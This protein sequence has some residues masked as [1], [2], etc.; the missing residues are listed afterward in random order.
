MTRRVKT[1]LKIAGIV[2]LAGAVAVLAYALLF[3]PLFA[4]SPVKF[5][6][7]ELRLARC[8]ILYPRGATPDPA[9]S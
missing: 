4:F 5:G 3:G 2:F 9:Y 1:G 7:D 8:T 6:F